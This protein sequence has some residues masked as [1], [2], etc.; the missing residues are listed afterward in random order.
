MAISKAEEKARLKVLKELETKSHKTLNKVR[1]RL[2]QIRRRLAHGPFS[3]I[4]VGGV[5]HGLRELNERLSGHIGE[6]ASTAESDDT[7][8]ILNT[9][10]SRIGLLR[11]NIEHID[12]FI[13]KLK[14]APVG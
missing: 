9:R 14:T 1:K 8:E 3:A 10:N 7:K 11:T 4:E 5:I 6:L 12:D 13:K 2:V